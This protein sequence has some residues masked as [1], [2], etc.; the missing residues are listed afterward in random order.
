VLRA[1]DRLKLAES[2][3]VVLVADHGEEFYERGWLGHTRTLH[4]ELVR[5]PLIVSAPEMAPAVVDDPVS[6][7]GL[8]PTLLDLLGIRPRERD[9][10]AQA[11]S[12]APLVRGEPHSNREPIY[13]STEFFRHAGGDTH[14][15]AGE[16]ERRHALI[17][18][19]VKLIEDR[20]SGRQQLYDLR[21]DPLERRDLIETIGSRTR[22]ELEELLRAVAERSRAERLEGAAESTAPSAQELRLLRE[23]GYI[24]E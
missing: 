21:D 12:F 4:E 1:L 22:S 23:L 5:V 18:G 20:A 3:V 10:A 16:L 17:V 7:T 2:T 19:D 14:A 24:A 13:L 15:E 11:G 6:L 8:M 9:G